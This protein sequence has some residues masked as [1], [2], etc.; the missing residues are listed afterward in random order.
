MD[1]VNDW[2][3]PDDPDDA[4]ECEDCGCPMPTGSYGNALCLECR[5]ANWDD[6]L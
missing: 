3:S 4:P 6:D 5:D 2:L 1:D